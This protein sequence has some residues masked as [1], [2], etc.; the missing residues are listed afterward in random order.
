VA[1]S[2]DPLRKIDGRPYVSARAL[3]NIRAFAE[4]V[5]ATGDG[6]PPALRLD[7]LCAEVEDFLARI[8]PARRTFLIGVFALSILVPLF[9]GR[10]TKMSSIP[11]PERVVTL[12]RIED[13]ALGGIVLGMKMLLCIL[14]YEH[15]ASARSVGFDGRCLVDDS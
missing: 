4:A 2:A 12:T 5:F 1:S 13:S 10:F 6:P 15:P 14:Y 8:G 3:E 7:W 9:S 11:L